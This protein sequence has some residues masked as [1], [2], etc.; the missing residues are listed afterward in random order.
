MVSDG[1]IDRVFARLGEARGVDPRLSHNKD[2]VK[3][4]LFGAD[5][6]TETVAGRP[7]LGAVTDRGPSSA[8]ARPLPRPRV[9]SGP[10]PERIGRFVV[11]GPLGKGGMGKVYRAFDDVLERQVAVKVVHAEVG[12]RHG[13]RLLREAQALARLSHPNVVQVYEVGEVGGRLFIAMELIRGQTLRQW[14]RQEPRPGW[15]ACL[16]TY[17]KA[18]RGLEAAH[19]KGL[20]HRDF[21]PSNC[22][23][24]DEGR[25]RVLDFGL[26]RDSNPSEDLAEL[27]GFGGPVDGAA[28]S[29]SSSGSSS[30]ALMERLTE[31]GSVVGTRAYM[32]PEQLG[33][34]VVV[35]AKSDQFAFCVALYEALCGHLP[36]SEDPMPA[37]L[38]MASGVGP[39]PQPLP[40]GS[41][42][43]RWLQRAVVRGL[44]ADPRERWPSMAAL[45]WE[46][47]RRQRSAGVRRLSLLTGALLGVVL[48]GLVM[49]SREPPGPSVCAEAQQQLEGVWDDER[50]QVVREAILN[51]E[52]PYAAKTQS[53]VERQLDHYAQEWSHG[54]TEACEATRVHHEQPVEALELR[55]RCLRLRRSAL[56]HDVELLA[57]ADHDL[58]ERAVELVTE[59]PRI[60]AC[61]DLSALS[62]SSGVARIPGGAQRL[63]AL[64][65]H[66]GRMR[67]L[68]TI[69]RHR[70]AIVELAPLTRDAH[71][72]GDQSLLA[73]VL[74][75]GGQLHM[76][77]GRDEQ[78]EQYF[79]AAQIR[80]LEHGAD[81]VALEAMAGQIHL[82]GVEREQTGRALELA[83]DV[84]LPLVR[85]HGRDDALEA[86]VLTALAQVRTV[87]GEHR[88]AEARYR[89][90]LAIL[91]R[92][93][94]RGD[95]ALVEAH[96][97]L[98]Q[99]LRE[100]ERFDDAEQ[101]YR[102]ALHARESRLGD[103]HPEAAYQR[104]NL[105]NVLLARGKLDEAEQHFREALEILASA[106]TVHAK[107]I[108]HARA[109]LGTALHMHQRYSEAEQELRQA[110]SL[111]ERELDPDQLR[112]AKVRLDIA[113][114][115]TEQGRA[116]EAIDEYQGILGV[117]RHS[118]PTPS[119][120]R[121]MVKCLRDLGLLLV[122]QGRTREADARYR[123]ALEILEPGQ[124]ARG[125]LHANVLNR[126]GDLLLIK[127]SDTDAEHSFLQALEIYEQLYGPVHQKIGH[128]LK[129]IAGVHQRRKQWPLA[130]ARLERTR[131]I[132]ETTRAKP[133]AIAEV[134]QA[135]AEVR[136]H[137]EPTR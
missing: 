45:L 99:T 30:S 1:S 93:R 91:G 120:N 80:G 43:P 133:E 106:S 66:L 55:Q 5:K 70:E 135:L 82:M 129:R 32:A 57:D 46:L 96:D 34:R 103:T 39:M 49:S 53:S 137:I 52:L 63:E 128:T 26:A 42:A 127:G 118:E 61:A 104:T 112:V 8:G 19:A 44:A 38:D 33:G 71:R 109:S 134:E 100:Q 95:T 123:Q 17:V 36:F 108:A 12:V 20:I 126:H 73:E 50:R 76:A 48:T 86:K 105:G 84:A 68:E 22:M 132:Y 64:R 27:P 102:R 116:L 90:A 98:A 72:L 75:L 131:A 51:T 83:Q 113:V 54:Y 89:Q 60:D 125:A 62:R 124:E 74:L 28:S 40:M 92:V 121:L 41:H 122:H 65:T 2:Q 11:L 9:P 81:A 25:V 29:A 69:G 23:F 56:A 85:R 47:E 111:F 21:K 77:L 14:Q 110:L 136:A 78:A 117:L 58:V 88:E 130:M 114:V 94:V 35:D 4:R 79:R 97:G 6:S 115:L 7:R 15:K 37:L 10:A 3:A 59:L 31:T 87:R 18:G 101:L 119:R 24:D 107:R 16:D 13:R 67:S